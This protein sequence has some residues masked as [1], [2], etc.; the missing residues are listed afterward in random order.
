[1]M[2][3]PPAKRRR[4]SVAPL[5]AARQVATPQQGSPRK[6]SC[7]AA[8]VE[9]PE[10]QKGCAFLELLDGP[11]LGAAGKLEAKELCALD[12]AC[13]ALRKTNCSQGPW[14]ALGVTNF[15]GMELDKEGLFDPSHGPKKATKEEELKGSKGP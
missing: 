14:R 5:S 10:E 4:P 8:L 9:L 7:S 15:E 11:Y 1:M 12:A 2:Y 13:K 6:Q 3:G